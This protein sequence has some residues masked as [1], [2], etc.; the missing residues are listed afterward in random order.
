MIGNLNVDLIAMRGNN[1]SYMHL[2][3]ISNFQIV[4]DTL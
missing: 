4:K 2:N 1:A 3:Q